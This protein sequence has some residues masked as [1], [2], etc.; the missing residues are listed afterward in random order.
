MLHLDSPTAI[1]LCALVGTGWWFSRFILPL[2]ESNPNLVE[3]YDPIHSLV[4]ETVDVSKWV[5]AISTFS[6]GYVIVQWMWHPDDDRIVLHNYC[7]AFLYMLKSATMILCPLR[8]PSDA[9]PIL[10]KTI[11]FLAGGT[12]FQNDLMFSGHVAHSSLLMF[13]FSEHRL[14]WFF[15]T[16]VLSYALLISKTHYTIDILVG[17]TASSTMVNLLRHWLEP[18]GGQM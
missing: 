13:I 1:S 15:A 17:I 12:N 4:S 18:A 2:N 6:I 16:L 14:I 8:P 3:I 7:L 11:S 10:D 9:K 5:S